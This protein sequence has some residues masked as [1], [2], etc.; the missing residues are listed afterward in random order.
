MLPENILTSNHENGFCIFSED[1]SKTNVIVIV[2][3]FNVIVI[4]YI[5]ILF[6]CNH[7]RACDK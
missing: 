4:D 7:N 6:I 2:I 3:T 5:V 1:V